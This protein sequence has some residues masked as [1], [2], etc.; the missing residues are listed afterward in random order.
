MSD[1]RYKKKHTLEWEGGFFFAALW[2]RSV[3]VFFLYTLVAFQYSGFCLFFFLGQYTKNNELCTIIIIKTP[4]EK[5]TIQTA[6][7]T[8]YCC[9]DDR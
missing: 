6:H 5:A 3:F 2:E 9:R 8:L 1:Q 7:I 4:P